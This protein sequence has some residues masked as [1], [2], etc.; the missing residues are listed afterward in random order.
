M[1]VLLQPA[2]LLHRRPYRDSSQLLEVLCADYGRVGLVARGTRRRSRGGASGA[3]LQPFYPLLLSFSG[4]GELRSLTGVETGGG[5]AALRGNALLSGFYLNELLVRLLHRDDPQPEV[6]R[7]YAL[8]LAELAGSDVADADIESSLRRFEFQLLEALGYRVELDVDA[9]YGEPIDVRGHY[10]F[11]PGA[12]LQRDAGGVAEAGIYAGEDLL[13]VSRGDFKGRAGRVAKALT[14]TAL[15]PL[16][17]DRP[18][19]SR[20]LFRARRAHGKTD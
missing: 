10:R 5:I 11:H 17:G 20:E 15:A 3:L 19:R 6:F 4:T 14:R 8:A 16:L 13:A 12:G 2:Y 9:E 7:A 18:L 1:R